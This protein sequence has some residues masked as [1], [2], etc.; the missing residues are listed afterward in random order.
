M[1]EPPHPGRFD[2]EHFLLC[3]H[4][5]R[6]PDAT[7]MSQMS[8]TRRDSSFHGCACSSCAATGVVLPHL[9]SG[10]RTGRRPAV[11]LVSSAGERT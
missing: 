10:P 3:P 7:S 5:G 6:A 8:H 1:V 9:Q 2:N 4:I 11:H